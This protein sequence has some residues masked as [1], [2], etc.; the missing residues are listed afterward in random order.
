MG[1]GGGGGGGVGRR[2]SGERVGGEVGVLHGIVSFTDPHLSI[3]ILVTIYHFVYFQANKKKV[4]FCLLV[5]RHQNHILNCYRT[6]H[7]ALLGISNHQSHVGSC[8]LF[9]HWKTGWALATVQH[10][11]QIN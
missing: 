10:K 3:E 2:E 7:A 11:R 6:P 1:N 5:I 9:I 8:N 4:T